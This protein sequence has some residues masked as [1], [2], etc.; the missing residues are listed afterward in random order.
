MAGQRHKTTG[1]TNAPVERERREQDLVPP[2]GQ[3]AIGKG[4][5]RKSKPPRKRRA[6]EGL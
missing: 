5:N 3:S 4:R 6:A 1:I 2:R